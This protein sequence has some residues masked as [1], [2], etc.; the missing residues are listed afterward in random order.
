MSEIIDRVARA[1]YESACGTIYESESA[2]RPEE[3][4]WF[5]KWDEL[6]ADAQ[7]DKRAAARSART[8]MARARKDARAAIKAMREPTKNMLDEV[9]AFGH[10]MTHEEATFFWHEMIDAALA[11]ADE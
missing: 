3:A 2:N 9:T 1:I 4:P 7:S 11:K 10:V 6:I 5:P 8:A